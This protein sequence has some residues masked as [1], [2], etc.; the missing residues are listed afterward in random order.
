MK[1][2]VIVDSIFEYPLSEKLV[3]VLETPH[4]ARS[5]W[6]GAIENSD[7]VVDYCTSKGRVVLNLM[8]FGRTI[9]ITTGKPINF[10]K[11]RFRQ[12]VD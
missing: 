5:L 1:Y 3:D 2:K 7:A 4:I 6:A 8:R 9:Y 11:F 10:D 12:E